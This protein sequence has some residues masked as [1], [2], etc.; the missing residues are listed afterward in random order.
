MSD[1]VG[2]TKQ[3]WDRGRV[4]KKEILDTQEKYTLAPT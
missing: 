2:F 3:Q 1:M 4:S